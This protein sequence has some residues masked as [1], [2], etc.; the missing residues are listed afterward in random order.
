MNSENLTS[1]EIVKANILRI[2]FYL[3]GLRPMPPPASGD[4]WRL[5]RNSCFKGFWAPGGVPNRFLSK[6]CC[7]HSFF[8]RILLEKIFFF[9]RKKSG[10]CQKS[11]KFRFFPK[12]S[13]LSISGPRGCENRNQR[14]EMLVKSG[15]KS[16]FY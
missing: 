16:I 6:F 5:T 4:A 9:F 7:R 15:L 2:L 11:K 12:I 10:F 8:H 14:I 3:R 1:S 13:F